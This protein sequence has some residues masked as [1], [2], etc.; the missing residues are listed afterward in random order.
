[1][2]LSLAECT[3]T[4][5]PITEDCALIRYLLQNSR[6][7]E[8]ECTVAKQVTIHSQRK[9]P[10]SLLALLQ[11]TK[12]KFSQASCVDLCSRC[13][14]KRKPILRR[15][16]TMNIAT[17]M[18]IQAPDHPAQRKMNLYLLRALDHFHTLRGVCPNPFTT[19]LCSFTVK[20]AKNY[21]NRS[22]SVSSPPHQHETLS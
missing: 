16:T 22:S 15:P 12:V 3:W 17:L 2:D 13:I 10:D 21:L 18:K 7:A 11:Y 4:R 20:I 19:N 8:N 6:V 1:M 14:I 9:F 5:W